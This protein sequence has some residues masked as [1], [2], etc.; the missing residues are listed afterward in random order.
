MLGIVNSMVPKKK[1]LGSDHFIIKNKSNARGQVRNFGLKRK[2]RW[3]YSSLI[4]S[5]KIAPFTREILKKESKKK[6][7]Q[8]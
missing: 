1:N 8:A 4:F 7:K 5:C 6:Q 3:N 2:L